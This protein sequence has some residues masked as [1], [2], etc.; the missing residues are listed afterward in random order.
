MS[1]ED[2]PPTWPEEQRRAL[3]AEMERR[4]EAQVRVGRGLAVGLVAIAAAGVILRI[5]EEWWV[6]AVGAV[7]LA[8]VVFRLANWKCP[9][10]GERLPTRERTARCP[11]CGAPLE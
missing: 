10:C 9:S 3:R 11:G 6:P 4:R 2:S 8:G 1:D 5:P 7:A